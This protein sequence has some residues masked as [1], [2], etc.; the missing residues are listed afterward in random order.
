MSGPHHWSDTAAN[1]G[2]SDPNADLRPGRSANTVLGAI[3]GLMATVAL[4]RDDADG[5]LVASLGANNVYTVTTNEGLIDPTTQV[6]GLVPAITKPF[7]VRVWLPA[8]NTAVATAAP[9]IAIDG[10]AAVPLTRRDGSALADG[11]LTGFPVEILGDVL[12]PGPYGRARI[13]D[14]LRSDIIALKLPPSNQATT[15]IFAPNVVYSDLPTANTPYNTQGLVISGASNAII[16]S[17]VGLRNDQS[18][19]TGVISYLTCS[20]GA[21]S[22]YVGARILNGAQIPLQLTWTV[23]G[24]DRSKSYSFYQYAQKDTA[25]GPILVLD[26]SLIAIHDGN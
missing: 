9:T 23:R 21:Q 19:P 11:D 15:Q 10:A 26:A 22:Q 13:L 14:L 4:A 8:L 1:N 24:L 25:V 20:N 18:T 16:Y 2:S 7:V 6:N 17:S 12:T 3:R 5:T